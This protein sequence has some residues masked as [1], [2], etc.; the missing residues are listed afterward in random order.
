MRSIDVSDLPEPLAEV[1]ARLVE[2]LRRQLV[3]PEATKP[4][5]AVN[6][7]FVDG[8]VIGTLSREDLSDVG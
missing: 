5:G 2:E 8:A 3:Q 4:P 6:L 1:I 7:S